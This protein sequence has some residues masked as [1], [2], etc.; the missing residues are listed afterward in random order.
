MA[1]IRYSDEFIC[2]KCGRHTALVCHA[3]GTHQAHCMICDAYYDVDI[4]TVY[5]KREIEIAVRNARGADHAGDYQAAAWWE[6][7]ARELAQELEDSYGGSDHVEAVRMGSSTDPVPVLP[8]IH[9]AE[10]TP[11]RG[12]R[13]R[14]EDR[15]S[16]QDGQPEGVLSCLL[17][18]Q[19]L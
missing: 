7:R 10:G 17:L 14:H 6:A 3:D 2:P 9:R 8:G 19:Q 18:Q 12:A 13:G 5:L 11:V 15:D 4:A 16:I 1:K